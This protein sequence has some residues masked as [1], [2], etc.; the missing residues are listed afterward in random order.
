MARSLMANGPK[1]RRLRKTQGYSQEGLAVAISCDVKTIHNAELGKRVHVETLL[2]I[3][4]ALHV[5]L[6]VI[7]IGSDDPEEFLEVRLRRI[8]HWRD[9]FDRKELESIVEVYHDEAQ[10][11]YPGLGLLTVGGTAIGKQAIRQQLESIFQELHFDPWPETSERIHA[12]ENYVFLRGELTG[13]VR[14]SGLRFTSLAI[15]EFEF[16][17]TRIRRH[18][19]MFD[20]SSLHRR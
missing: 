17:R 11:T 2:K 12:S 20:T 4:Q 19:G 16:E 18:T 8:R 5:E 10:V 3:A 6:A 14:S 7:H 9:C 1:I 13:L 15:H